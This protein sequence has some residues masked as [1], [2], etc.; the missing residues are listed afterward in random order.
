MLVVNKIVEVSAL[1]VHSLDLYI[2]TSDLPCCLLYA[3][4]RHVYTVCI[5]DPKGCLLYIPL[6]VLYQHSGE[7]KGNFQVY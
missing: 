6:Y 5:N 7:L 4:F 3:F 1:H 2:W